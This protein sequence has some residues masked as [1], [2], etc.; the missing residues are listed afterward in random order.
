MGHDQHELF[1]AIA[2]NNI[3]AA[4]GA[5]HILSDRT[6]DRISGRVAERIVEALEVV[7]IDHHHAEGLT[8]APG[9]ALFPAER[10]FDITA[11]VQAGQPVMHDLLS[12][13]EI[14]LREF[15]LRPQP[16]LYLLIQG[17]PGYLEL[18]VPLCDISIQLGVQSL[19]F[20]DVPMEFPRYRA[21]ER[22][23]GFMI[24][25]R[26]ARRGLRPGK[27]CIDHRKQRLRTGRLGNER[28]AEG[29]CQSFGFDLDVGGGSKYH[30]GLDEVGI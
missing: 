6:Q 24:G 29:V 30:S 25:P 16:L 7:D 5:L 20:R 2:G 18:R 10:L 1:T 27:R 12:Q 22:V 3:L 11:V 15:L 17:G 28:H 21:Q 14:S 4:G 13:V 26:L 19:Q 9:A 23:D 8:C